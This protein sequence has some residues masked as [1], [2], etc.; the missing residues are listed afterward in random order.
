[1]SASDGRTML[2]S[3]SGFSLEEIE[4]EQWV[5]VEIASGYRLLH[6]EAVAI[7]L[8]AETL[9][10]ESLGIAEK[11]LTKVLAPTLSELGLPVWIPDEIPHQAIIRAMHVDKKRTNGTVC[12]TLPIRIG[13]VKVGVEVGDLETALKLTSKAQIMDAITN[14]RHF[15]SEKSKR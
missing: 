12:F 10:A 7:G 13:E 11:G 1:M 5:A 3:P 2:I 4:P 8:V 9:L 15:P 14:G 6:G